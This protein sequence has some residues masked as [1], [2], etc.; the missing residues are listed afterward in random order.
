MEFSVCTNSFYGQGI[1]S[2]DTGRELNVHKTPRRR[3]GRLLNVLCESRFFYERS[4]K[5]RAFWSCYT[6]SSLNM[7][8]YKSLHLTATLK[9]NKNKFSKYIQEFNTNHFVNVN[10]AFLMFSLLRILA[11]KKHHKQISSQKRYK[12]RYGHL[13]I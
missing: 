8:F 1:N 4:P 10:D 11:G 2:V 13:G 6:W 3:P 5:E 7:S 12:Y 9:Q